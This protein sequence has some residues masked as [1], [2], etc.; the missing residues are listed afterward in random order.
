ML[1]SQP[2]GAA[3]EQDLLTLRVVSVS[4]EAENVISLRLAGFD[5]ALPGWTPGAHVD[6]HLPSGA[7]RQY[8]LCGAP[9]PE[10]R[11]AVLRRDAGR[12]GSLEV[13]GLRPGDIVRASRPRN[14][15]PLEPARRYL[16]VAG[17]IGVTP[18]LAMAR[19]AEARGVDW[20]VVYLGHAAERMA[21]ARELAAL[22]PF[23]VA[24][25]ET[26]ARGRPDLDALL[27]EAD[28]AQIYACGP[29]ALL[30]GLETAARE[31]GRERDLHTERFEPVSTLR[32]ED[33]G[34]L[35][36]LARSGRQVVV[37]ADQTLLDAMRAAGVEVASSCEQ[38]FCGTCECRVLAGE[39]DHRDT[40]LSD[41]ERAR[42]EVMMPCVSRALSDALTL[43]L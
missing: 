34:I 9:G 31:A 5:G 39:P 14:L 23:R 20:R 35:L 6:L 15:F 33:G 42:G 2:R 8:S 29:D 7:S 41:E 18:I 10:W 43:D 12:G 27:R 24:L 38:G 4:L 21:F 26:G 17:G 40:L 11:V 16:F 13:H 19:E 1:D 28:G 3:L 25:I 30:A 37:P 36:T 22:D 32:P